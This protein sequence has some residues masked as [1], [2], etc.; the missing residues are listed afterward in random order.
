MTLKEALLVFLKNDTMIDWEKESN[1][2]ISKKLAYNTALSDIADFIKR[3]EKGQVGQEF[4]DHL[5]K[6]SKDE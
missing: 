6:R 2:L 3:Y 4:L 1:E 5:A